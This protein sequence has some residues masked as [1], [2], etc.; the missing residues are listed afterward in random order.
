MSSL[1]EQMRAA[2]MKGEAKK[3]KKGKPRKTKEPPKES[4]SITIC[5]S[6]ENHTGMEILGE[7]IELK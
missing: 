4:W 1:L 5:E 3:S 6:G 2:R 7:K